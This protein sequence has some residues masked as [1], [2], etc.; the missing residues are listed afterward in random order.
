MS[1]DSFL[2]ERLGTLSRSEGSLLMLLVSVLWGVGLVIDK[3]AIRFSSSQLHG[4]VVSVGTAFIYYFISQS[5]KKGIWVEWK[6]SLGKSLYLFPL[7]AGLAF[8]LQFIAIVDF[9]VA[10]YDA[11]KRSTTV[12]MGLVISILFVYFRILFL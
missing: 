3:V 2:K 11:I 12:V 7:V 9:P 10:F 4:S 6:N 8:A 5:N 1:D